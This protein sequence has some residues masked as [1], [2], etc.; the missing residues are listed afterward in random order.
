MGPS[1]PN[2]RPKLE[3]IHRASQTQA[4]TMITDYC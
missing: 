4:G 3:P 1:R 2:F